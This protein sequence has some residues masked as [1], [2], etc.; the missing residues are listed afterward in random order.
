MDL[1]TKT[2]SPLDE[3]RKQEK[4]MSGL[5]IEDLNKEKQFAVKIYK[6]DLNSSEGFGQLK[7]ALKEVRHLRELTLKECPH[8]ISSFETYI[9]RERSNSNNIIRVKSVFEYARK[10]SLLDLI[11]SNFVLTSEHTK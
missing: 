4:L 1:Y 8:I 11:K 10:G 9:E 7:E 2:T 5:L 3:Q 6:F